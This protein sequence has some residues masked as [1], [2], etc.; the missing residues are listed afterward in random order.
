M[1]KMYPEQGSRDPRVIQQ[2]SETSPLEIELELSRCDFGSRSTSAFLL[3]VDV[4]VQSRQEAAFITV[5]GKVCQ[6][7]VNPT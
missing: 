4:W 5:W 7:Q 6:L 3:D 1:E 2:A